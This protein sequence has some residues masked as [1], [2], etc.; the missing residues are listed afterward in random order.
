MV[1]A[2]SLR[3]KP[4]RLNTE[5]KPK[6]FLSFQIFEPGSSSVFLRS[7]ALG[8]NCRSPHLCKSTAGGQQ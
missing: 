5:K 2:R 8:L 1:T 6:T 3:C 7:E 4:K